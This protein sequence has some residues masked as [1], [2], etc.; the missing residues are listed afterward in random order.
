MSQGAPDS[1]GILGVIA[2]LLEMT[3]NQP[4]VLERRRLIMTARW[5]PGERGEGNQHGDHQSGTA[6]RQIA[7]GAHRPIRGGRGAAACGDQP[8]GIAGEGQKKKD[9]IESEKTRHQ[10]RTRSYKA[11]MIPAVTPHIYRPSNGIS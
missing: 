11:R 6:Y 8:R 2:A 7:D 3:G 10:P 5:R 9:R 4:A 1:V